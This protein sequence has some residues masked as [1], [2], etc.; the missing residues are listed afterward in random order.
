M[1]HTPNPEDHPID[2][3]ITEEQ[4]QR[5]MDEIGASG[6]NGQELANSPLGTLGSRMQMAE[7]LYPKQEIDPAMAA[8]LYF[9][10]MG[11]AAGRPGATLLSSFAEGFEDPAKYLTQV[12][13]ANQA[14]EQA[15]AKAILGT[16]SSTGVAGSRPFKVLAAWKN[17]LVQYL[18]KDGQMVV[19]QFNKEYTDPVQIKKLIDTAN[20]DSYR[21]DLETGTVAAEVAGLKVGKEGAFEIAKSQMAEAQKAIPR[22]VGNIQNYKEGIAAIND[23]A[24]SG[25]FMRMLPSMRTASIQLDNV[26][27]RL[28]LDVVGSV[29]FGALS[30]GELSMAMSTAAPTSFAPEYLKEWFENRIK[31]KENLLKVSEDIA[32]FLSDGDT[33]MA[34]YYERKDRLQ[35]NGE[36]RATLG[37]SDVDEQYADSDIDQ[38]NQASSFS[39]DEIN[40]MNKADLLAV[41]ITTLNRAAKQAYI[42]KARELLQ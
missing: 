12:N 41:D 3:E 17:G 23:G 6:N 14:T 42:E 36:W 28:G 16:G 34:D 25:F 2:N 30:A 38:D 9:S 37:L 22:L 11:R 31:A 10:N 27:N 33:T 13:Q 29:T 24:Q 15:K 21:V 1:A 8:F 39:V 26:V 19:K 5:L 20:Q 7:Q 32:R 40:A 35:Q 4:R 18:T